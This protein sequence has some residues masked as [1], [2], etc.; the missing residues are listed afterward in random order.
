MGQPGFHEL[1]SPHDAPGRA[2][3]ALIELTRASRRIV[4][5]T[6]AG[7][8]T[9]SG[10]PDYRGPNGVWARSA[11][12]TLGD[13][14]SNPETRRAYWEARRVRYP[15]MRDTQPNAGHHALVALERAGLLHAV[16][17]QNIDGLHLAAGHAPERIIEL[18]GT[19]HR[20]RCLDC[21]A[22]W[23]AGQIH[24]RLEG[25]ES[26]P[27]CERCGGP[28]R[29]ATVLFGEALPRD[30][31]DR[32]LREAKA[33]DM[34]LV[35]GSSLVVNPAAK[36]PLVAKRHGARLAIVN[37]TPTPLD[38]MADVRVFGESGAILAALACA[39][40]HPDALPD[41]QERL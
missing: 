34:M 18:H 24:A 16:I 10:I 38:A 36:I 14:R 37:R 35:V 21:G 25:G 13:F 7:I 9:E 4:A 2:L 19:T 32:A 11:Y 6:G 40:A 22:S 23:D 15:Q 29:A 39:V 1:A 31:L 17:T 27:A 28:L 8:S 12:P 33:C 30:V 26:V 5:F 20:V 41:R 3:A